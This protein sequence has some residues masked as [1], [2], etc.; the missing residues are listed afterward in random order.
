VNEAPTDR[1]AG[2]QLV[3]LKRDLRVDDHVPLVEAARRGPVAAVYVVEPSWL[4]EA[5]FHPSQ[6]QFAL[7][8]LAEVEREVRARGGTVL[9]LHAELPD[10]FEQLWRRHPFTHLWA[11]EETGNA[12]TYARDKRVA[13]WAK[14]RGVAFFEVPQHGVFRPHRRRDGWAAR[15]AARMNL[16]LTRAPE[17]VLPWPATDSTPL[18][19][20]AE[21]GIT[22]STRSEV[23]AGGSVAARA[24]LRS[25]L[26]HRGVDYTRAMSSPVTAWDGCSRLSP[27]LAFGSIAL[28]RV[29]Q[30]VE[31]RASEI[32]A[33]GR[34]SGIDPRWGRSLASFRGRLRW[35]CHFMQKLEDETRLEHENL[36]RAYDGL[37]PSEPDEAKLRAFCEGKT[38]YPMID[39]CVRAL[40]ATGWIN[41]RM[42]AMLVSFASY[43]LWL[44]W[45]PTG[46]FLGRQFIDFE[47]G[48]HWSQMQMQSGTTGINTLRIYSPTKQVR[49]HD[50]T[51][52]FVRQWLPELARVPEARL[53]EP[54]TMLP[55][56]MRRAACR[57]G[58]DYPRPI[59][60]HAEAVAEAKRMLYAV[61]R[62]SSARAEA[63]AIVAKHGSRRAPP[64][65]RRK[66][67]A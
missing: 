54:W 35:H 58:L 53:A 48:I 19:T 62:T 42:R 65:R 40:V 26:S 13:S 61:R 6:L 41:F 10:A 25:F 15:W 14:A 57:I 7:E 5:E 43:H 22:P 32:R 50:P 47:A 28:R 2:L 38:G 45:R 44:D 37:R 31:R 59:V 21:L 51:G 27:H 24:T 56:E 12:R 4:A 67:A 1:P 39:A 16:P 66:G 9:V 29:Y 46:L 49:D 33:A 30:E 36:A 17:A 52:V 64:A 8:C 23:Q 63:G 18:P 11:H 20:L 3:W 34:S 60:D 55:D